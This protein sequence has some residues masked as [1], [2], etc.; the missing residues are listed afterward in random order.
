MTGTL[1]LPG[2]PARLQ[3]PMAA[4]YVGILDDEGRPDTSTFR[5]HVRKGLYPRPH[6]RPGE[7]QAWLKIELDETLTRLQQEEAS[8]HEEEEFE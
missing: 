1:S 2:W 5:E 6:K 8:A 3:A 7:R 4:A